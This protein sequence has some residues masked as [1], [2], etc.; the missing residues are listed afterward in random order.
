MKRDT[1]ELILLQQESIGGSVAAIFL[2]T[3]ERYNFRLMV[4]AA[5]VL[6]SPL[7]DWVEG[8][9]HGDRIFTS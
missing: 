4:Q 6:Q 5:V 8:D 1:R 9:C 3:S 2:P 7:I